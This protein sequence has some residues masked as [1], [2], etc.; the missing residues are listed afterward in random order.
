MTALSIVNFS[1]KYGDFLAVDNIS[2]EVKNG[3]IVGFI[4]K[5]GA[6]KSTVLRCIMNFLKPTNGECKVFELDSVKSDK[7]IRKL[8]GYMPSDA[9]FY[10]FAK[11]SEILQFTCSLVGVSYDE[12]VKLAE[13]FELDT[14]KKVSELSLGNRKKVSIICCLLGDKKLLILDEPTNGLDPLMQEKFFRLIH[15]RNKNGTTVF[16]S[17]HNLSEIEKVCH[18]VIIIK[19]GKIV[20]EIDLSS[21][22]RKKAQIVS[23]KTKDGT[24]NSY[25]FSGDINELISELAKLD[26]DNL[27]I[28]NSSIEDEFIKY[29]KEEN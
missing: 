2:F 28:K 10:N 5:N 14:K 24:S 12:A 9:S 23:Y 20:D 22:E 17:G 6:G 16:L 7:D 27:E 1:K 29:Y 25:E 4:G 13:Y 19:S 8:V 21:V 11:V 26:L 18:R 15:E 3:E